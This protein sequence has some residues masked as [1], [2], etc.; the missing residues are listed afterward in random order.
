[1]VVAYRAAP[2]YNKLLESMM[3]GNGSGT[4]TMENGMEWRV[5][6]REYKEKEEEE[7]EEVEVHSSL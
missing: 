3:I 5:E 2:L 4:F 7:E 6:S 1:V